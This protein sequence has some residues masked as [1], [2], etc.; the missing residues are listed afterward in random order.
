MRPLK[1]AVIGA[2]SRSFGLSTMAALLREKEIRGSTLALVDV[3]SESLEVMHA[4]ANRMSAEWDA[5]ATITA[6]ADRTEALRD[7]DFCILSVEKGDRATLW[8]L[9][10][11]IPTAEL[12]IERRGVLRAGAR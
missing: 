6:T 3:D 1:I 10:F 12:A 11:R 9:D 8:R 2:G 5:G 4:V 7:A